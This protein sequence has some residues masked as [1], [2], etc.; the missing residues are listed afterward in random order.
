MLLPAAA[1]PPYGP[2]PESA[3][4]LV[5]RW[6]WGK[7]KALVPTRSASPA[8]Q[9]QPAPLAVQEKV[10]PYVH[11]ESASAAET[12][13]V[14]QS[15][16]APVLDLSSAI[17]YQPKDW[18]LRATAG[19]AWRNFGQLHFQ[20]QD[21]ASRA[22]LPLL[23]P[24]QG[25]TVGPA[26]AASGYASRRYSNGFVNPDVGTAIAGDTGFFSYTADSQ[27]QGGL[28]VFTGEGATT[29]L[30]DVSTLSEQTSWSSDL[31]G[32]G[33]VVGV[34]MD[35]AVSA[36]MRLGASAQLG[37]W[38][39]EQ[40]ATGSRF[41]IEQRSV[42]SV[43]QVI[44]AY[45]TAGAILPGAPYSGTFLG[46]GPIILATPIRSVS[47]EVT[48]SVALLQ[49]RITQEVDLNVATLSF[50][51]T[52]AWQ[53]GRWSAQGA[54]GLA[55]N[56]VGWDARQREE[57]LASVNGGARRLLAAYESHASG[58]TLL[59][60]FYLQAAADYQLS[61]RW[62]LRMF[63]RYDWASG[64]LSL[65]TRYDR[66]DGGS[67]CGVS[68]LGRLVGQAGSAE[69]NDGASPAQAS[70][71]GVWVLEAGSLDS[72]GMRAFWCRFGTAMAK[73]AGSYEP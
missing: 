62:A 18:Q 10:Q 49:D 65:Y 41:L 23:V 53:Q 28:L 22:G 70:T 31:A 63:S 8:C 66:L 50:G 67:L 71:L 13:R 4:K 43:Q 61:K 57:L 36:H 39:I 26:G 52:L 3:P 5:V 35:G 38:Q 25:S 46:P 73:V 29:T 54:M 14:L 20:M 55:L 6:P 12:S 45:D 30:L 44:D 17:S 40:A 21:H 59:P 16:L 1:E 2:L 72:L 7:K 69:S 15:L 27:E 33:P 42:S 68:L 64:A 19:F 34:E 48:E 11:P 60:G 32:G 9:A 56:V 37:F 24:G 51:P 58:T 47:E